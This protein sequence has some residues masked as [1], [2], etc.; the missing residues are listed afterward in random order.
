M[1]CRERLLRSQKFLHFRRKQNH[2]LKLTDQSANHQCTQTSHFSNT[3]KNTKATRSP[4][5]TGKNQCESVMRDSP[6][7]A[8]SSTLSRTNTFLIR[9]SPSFRFSDP[10][11]SRQEVGRHRGRL[12]ESILFD[13]ELQCHRQPRDCRHD[14]GHAHPGQQMQKAELPEV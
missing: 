4:H 8:S 12:T 7:A 1:N 14:N 3:T 6:E 2:E 10:Q 9:R 11:P 13:R 5:P